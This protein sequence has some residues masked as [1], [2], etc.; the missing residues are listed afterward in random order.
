MARRYLL[1]I[2]PAHKNASV[3]QAQIQHRERFRAFRTGEKGHAFEAVDTLAPG[4]YV[5]ITDGAEETIASW[6]R[7]MGWRVEIDDLRDEPNDDE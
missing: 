2:Q 5:H 7:S 4:W 1:P 6:L 3:V